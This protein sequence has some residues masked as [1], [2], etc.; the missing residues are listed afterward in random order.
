MACSG[1]KNSV[2]GILAGVVGR[3]DH[4]TIYRVVY[5]APIIPRYRNRIT[6]SQAAK[7]PKHSRVA[8]H[9]INM[10]RN[11]HIPRLSRCGT[12]SRAGCS[13]EVVCELPVT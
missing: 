12:R 7:L 13:D 9:T 2:E 3:I 6:R 4:N 1:A 8:A 5:N 11:D 10:S